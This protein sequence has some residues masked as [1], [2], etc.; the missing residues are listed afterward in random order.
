MAKQVAWFNADGAVATAVYAGHVDWMCYRM[1]VVAAVRTAP[2]PD[3]VV[4][5]LYDTEVFAVAVA[6]GRRVATLMA[7][8]AE[9]PADLLVRTPTGAVATA[10]ALRAYSSSDGA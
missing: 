10:A 7:A 6:G 1:G 2:R 5:S 4:W 9:A 3:G 8:L